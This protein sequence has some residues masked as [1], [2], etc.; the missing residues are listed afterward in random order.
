MALP[1]EPR[2]KMINMMYLVLT[3]M[4]ALNVSSEILNAFKVVDKSLQNSSSNITIANNTLYKSLKDKLDDPKSAATAQIWEPKAEKAQALS[5]QMNDYIE[6][7][8]KDLKVAAELKVDK[9]TGNP[10]LDKN[11][12]EDFMEGNL[13]ASTRLFDTQGK[14]KDLE[15]KLLAYR[16]AMLA[17]DTEIAVKFA[18]TLPI[19]IDPPIGQDGKKK[20]F[21][22]AYFHMTPTVAALTILSKFQNNVKNAENQ[23]VSYIHSKIG[24]VKLKIDKFDALVGQS[25]NYL[26]PGDEL[27]ITAGIG[28]YSSAAIPIISINGSSVQT[29]EGQGIYKTTATGSG[30]HKISVVIHYKDQQNVEQVSTKDIEYTVGTPGGAAVMPDKMMVFYIGVDNPVTIGSPTGWDK[31]TVTINGGGGSFTSGSGSNRIVR[32]T[33]VGDATINVTANGK[34]SPFKFR[35]KTIPDPIIKVGP[36]AGGKMQSVVFKSQPFVRADLEHFDFQANF[37]VTGATMYFTGPQFRNTVS[38]TLTSGSMAPA[39]QY[40]DQCG[41]GSAVIFDNIKVVGPDGKTRTIQNPPG[42]SLF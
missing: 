6:H 4:L 32:V 37:S 7:L 36:S 2:Q 30:P 26:M 16:Q 38:V 9:T 1:K 34:T 25:S 28:A 27:T 19:D 11:G 23:V 12:N 3:A 22:A 24:E 5:N 41:P 35:V 18:K 40:L 20:E 13:E 10:L 8:K 33:E 31:T 29:V 39:K 15:T 17:I 14:G 42:F 21:T